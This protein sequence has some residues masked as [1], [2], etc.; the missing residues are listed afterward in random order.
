[1]H[2]F[3]RV[4]GILSLKERKK[5]SKR[6]WNFIKNSYLLQ[7]QEKTRSVSEHH[8][9]SWPLPSR[10]GKEDYKSY[11]IMYGKYACHK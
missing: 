8:H 4:K 11:L 5:G 1:M 3:L 7:Q 2:N 9:Y 6:V 10:V